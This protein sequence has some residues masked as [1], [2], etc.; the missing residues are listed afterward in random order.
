MSGLL[1]II[2]LHALLI[3]LA[4][5]FA[6]EFVIAI[7]LYVLVMHDIEKISAANYDRD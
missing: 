3:V 1:L 4:I 7:V 6:A 2:L 5:A